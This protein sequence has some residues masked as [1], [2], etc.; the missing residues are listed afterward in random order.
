MAGDLLSFIDFL[1]NYALFND[2]LGL[3]V[4]GRMFSF[5]VALECCKSFAP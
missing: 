3:S 2:T 5:R 4:S 1:L